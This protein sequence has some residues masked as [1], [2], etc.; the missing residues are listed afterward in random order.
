MSGP[1]V[2]VKFDGDPRGLTAATDQV[3]SALSATTQ[4]VQS[5]SQ[6]INAM[7]GFGGIAASLG[8]LASVGTI[9]SLIA[10]TI[11]WAA[12]M[13]HLATK[14]GA[15]VENLSALSKIARIS[16]TDIGQLETNLIRLSKALAGGDEETK[17]AGHALEFLGLKAKELREID[18]AE[19]LE[20]IAAA[21]NEYGDGSGKTALA[22]AIFGREGAQL[23]PLLK[24]LAEQHLTGGKLTA[25]QAEAA[26]TLEKAWRKTNYE[27]G[28]WAK[29]IAID[30]IPTLASLL[31]FV[32]ETK[33]GIYQVGSSLAVVANDIVVFAQVAAAA[34]AGGFTSEGQDHI[35]QL[36]EGRARFVEAANED[37]V[38]RLSSF[39]SLR[40]KIDAV[41]AGKDEKKP[42]ANYTA[43]DPGE[44]KDTKEKDLS[45][46][47]Y[48]ALAVADK[49]AEKWQEQQDA[50]RR[51]MQIMPDAQRKLA[52]S[53]AAID[54]DYAEGER[55][56]VDM[57]GKKEISPEK[58][59]E[60][61]MKLKSAMAAARE[62]TLATAQEQARLNESWEHGADQALQK[63]LDT[64]SNVAASS[65]RLMTNAFK[66]MEDALVNFVKTGKLDFKSLA[67]QIVTDMIRM[68]IQS[69]ITKPLASLAQD[70]G[71]FGSIFS[72]LGSGLKAM[73]PSFDV[74]TD[75]VPYDMVAQIHKGEKITPADQNTGSGNIPSIVIQQTITIDSRSDQATIM[76]GMIQ[77]KNAAVAEIHNSMRRGGAFA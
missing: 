10:D 30:L 15:S 66:G 57:M 13:E 72:A 34:I 38:K 21:M 1:G 27:G 44:P 3:R 6:S 29:Q 32:T 24:D 17:G 61:I 60:A 43:R 4:G 40:D 22:L 18:P 16:G 25:A 36:L 33:M 73:L 9:K 74:G 48:E 14:T 55:R 41:L 49:L 64:V 54:K 65:E 69:S 42:K 53:M 52:S 56:I 70:S 7:P 63:Y 39:T 67:D 46:A 37:M 45:K 71:G 19:A 47:N 50:A 76:A 23:L 28:L 11:E 20:K 68:Q 26:L 62:E 58:Y 31:D 2:S 8:A 75:Y 35:K 5:L 12:G 77:A 59:V 51:A